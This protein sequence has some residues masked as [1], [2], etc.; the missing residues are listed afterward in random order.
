MRQYGLS[1]SLSRYIGL[2]YRLGGTTFHCSGDFLVDQGIA[3]PEEV[4]VKS[5]LCH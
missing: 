4:R 1:S 3:D 5:H 2:R